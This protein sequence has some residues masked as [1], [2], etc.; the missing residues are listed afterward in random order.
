MPLLM[1]NLQLLYLFYNL[2][3]IGLVFVD[4]YI[5]DILTY[6]VDFFWFHFWS[7]QKAKY[8]SRVTWVFGPLSSNFRISK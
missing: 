7:R 6:S 3:N 1:S 5:W 4:T 8:N 2:Y